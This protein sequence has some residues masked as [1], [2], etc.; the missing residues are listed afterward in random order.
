M[1]PIY[2]DNAATTPLDPAVADGLAER[3]RTLYGNPGS[4]HPIGRAAG[5]ALDEARAR[6]ARRLGGQPQQ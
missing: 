1:H 4:S 3:H 2:L 5:R 6:L